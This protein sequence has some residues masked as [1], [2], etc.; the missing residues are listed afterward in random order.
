MAGAFLLLILIMMVLA[1]VYGLGSLALIFMMRLLLHLAHV[2]DV[3]ITAI[4]ILET[5]L[6]FLLGYCGFL[7]C[8]VRFGFLLGAATIA[9]D[10]IGLAESWTLSHRNFWR[11]FIV[12]LAIFLPFVI[13]EGGFM[14][15]LGIFRFPPPETSP[16]VANAI[17][18]ARMAAMQSMLLHYWY[19]YLPVFGAMMV[20]LY[21]VLAGAGS[22]A[23]RAL[24]EDGES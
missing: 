10:R 19:I 22:F 17:M 13:I 12:S 3:A 9:Q 11:M 21:G 23:W 20:L 5:V 18:Q 16:A 8:G 15:A 24:T 7:Y 1:V 6:I 14:A 4:A 2:S